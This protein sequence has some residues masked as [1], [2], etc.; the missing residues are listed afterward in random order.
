MQPM[1][2]MPERKQGAFDGRAHDGRYDGA[3]G[4]A[5]ALWEELRT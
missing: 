3:G 2:Q 1:E 5:A 4:E